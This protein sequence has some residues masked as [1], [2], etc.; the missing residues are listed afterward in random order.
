MITLAEFW[1]V[2]LKRTFSRYCEKFIYTSIG[3]V[4][5]E[6][7]A[8]SEWCSLTQSCECHGGV[9]GVI[10]HSISYERVSVGLT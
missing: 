1:N 10:W 4:F 9:G 3:P 2:S 8:L 7:R 6:H 5:E